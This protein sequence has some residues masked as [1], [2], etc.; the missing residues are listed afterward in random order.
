[1]RSAISIL[2]QASMPSRPGEELISRTLGPSWERIMS[3][4][5]TRKPILLAALSAI[6]R[7]SAVIL[8]GLAF[9]PQCKLDL[10]SPS[11]AWRCMVATTLLPTTKHRIS[12]PLASLMNS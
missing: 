3:T 5:A 1:M 7:S 2:L 6:W 11:S 12:F 10:N 9:P 8:M 4:P